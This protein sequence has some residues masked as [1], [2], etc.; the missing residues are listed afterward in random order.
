MSIKKPLISNEV[1]LLVEIGSGDLKV[2]SLIFS[3]ELEIV[4]GSTQ[5]RN[6]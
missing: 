1:V 2:K 6:G 5:T 4:T 3:G